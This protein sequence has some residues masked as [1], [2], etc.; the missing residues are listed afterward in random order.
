MI[1]ERYIDGGNGWDQLSYQSSPYSVTIGKTLQSFG[2]KP[3]V[4]YR[5]AEV[6]GAQSQVVAVEQVVGSNFNDILYS[7]GDVEPSLTDTSFQ[8]TISGLSNLSAGN[9]ND[10]LY[11]CAN[12]SNFSAFA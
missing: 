7:Y 8:A 12:Q 9:G 6:N 11:S 4:S 2:S 10:Q 3:I 5:L 1:E